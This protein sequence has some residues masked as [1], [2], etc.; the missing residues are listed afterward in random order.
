LKFVTPAQRHRGEDSVILEQRH[1]LYEAAKA[2]HPERWSG[3][4][5]NW[6][7]DKI[8]YLNPGKPMKKEGELKQNAA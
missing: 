8:V 3:P 6:I 2:K 4:T 7:P 5:R 1:A